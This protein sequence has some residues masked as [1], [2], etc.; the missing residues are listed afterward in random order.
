LF[1]AVLKNL[2]NV[3]DVDEDMRYMAKDR[4]F[5]YCRLDVDQGLENMELDEWDEGLGTLESIRRHT[6]KYLEKPE[7]QKR[8]ARLAEA[9][10]EARREREERWPQE[11]ITVS[12]FF[13]AVEVMRSR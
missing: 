3:S 8:M 5:G 10:V 2:T 12:S 9:L 13:L 7:V 6:E 4:G 11:K 1:R